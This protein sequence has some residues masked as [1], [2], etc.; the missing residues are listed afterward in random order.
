MNRSAQRGFTVIEIL[1]VVAV[2]VILT[3]VIIPRVVILRQQSTQE[4]N[5]FNAR[6]IANAI[7]R[8]QL[9]GGTV[10]NVSSVESVVTQLVDRQIICP[11]DKLT[12]R[13]ITMIAT[14]GY[15]FFYGTYDD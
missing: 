6:Q 13:Q 9:E 12:S 5:S 10:T 7:E 14:N 15:L 4:R 3:A 11:S 2:I 8:F 1:A